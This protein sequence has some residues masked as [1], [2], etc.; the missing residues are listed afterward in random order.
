M[1]WRVAD[2]V[3]G[4]AYRSLP[5]NSAGKGALELDACDAHALRRSGC[6]LDIE[7]VGEGGK[8]EGSELAEVSLGE[9]VGGLPGIWLSE[10]VFWRGV[11]VDCGDAG[12]VSSRGAGTLPRR[13]RQFRSEAFLKLDAFDVDSMSRV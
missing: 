4:G 10:G 13:P 8:N 12:V 9:F 7:E 3:N 1:D 5:A 6:R 2:V 11:S